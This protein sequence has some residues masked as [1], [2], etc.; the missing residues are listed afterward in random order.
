MALVLLVLR[1]WDSGKLRD[2][3]IAL[4]VALAAVFFGQDA[5]FAYPGVFLTLAIAAQRAHRFRHVAMT[6]AGAALTLGVVV[7]MYLLIWTKMG[8]T[9]EGEKYWGKKYDVFY[10]PGKHKSNRTEWTESH[11]Q[12]IAEMPGVRRRS[13]AA[14]KLFSKD[15]LEELPPMDCVVWL[16]LHVAGVWAVARRRYLRGALLIVLPLL[17][18]TAFNV[19]GFWPFGNFRTNLFALVYTA[20]IAAF[21]VDRDPARTRSWDLLPATVLVLL[22]FFVFERTYHAR[23]QF[24][25]VPASY[26]DAIRKLLFLQ[27]SDYK[28]PR[29]TIVADFWGCPGWDYYVKYNPTMRKLGPELTR[30]FEIECQRRAGDLMAESRRLLQSQKRVWV[31]ATKANVLKTVE[32]GWPHDLERDMRVMIG[33]K[34]HL[35]I[36]VTGKPPVIEL[37]PSEAGEAEP[38]APDDVHP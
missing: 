23:K 3:A 34:E 4:S 8:T 5:V 31:L 30:R 17:V 6:A 35:I 33:K 18:L 10:V 7:A 14:T 36:A 20:A 32:R 12:Q 15:R 11:Y 25:T 19:L 21:A 16:M 28:G 24:Y 9:E 26:P 38:E 22:P 13:W 27:G 2:L 37:P 29:E 1:Y